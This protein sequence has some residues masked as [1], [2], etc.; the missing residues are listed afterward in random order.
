MESLISII[1]PIF[2]EEK[3]IEKTLHK[4]L[5]LPLKGEILLIND[6]SEDKTLQ[7]L[8]KIKKNNKNKNFNLKIFNC[9]HQGLGA[10]LIFGFKN[11][12]NDIVLTT[13]ADGEHN[14]SSLPNMINF[15]IKNQEKYV[16]VFATRIMKYSLIRKFYNNLFHFF[17]KNFQ[18]KDP[19]I[20]M[21][22]GTR[23][24]KLETIKKMDLQEKG[25]LIQLEMN[26]KL[27]KYG[28]VYNYFVKYNKRGIDEGKKLYG[29]E[30]NKFLIKS[31]FFSIR[32][33]LTQFSV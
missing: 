26:F 11:C 3:I 15:F 19:I 13:D 4:I 2:N 10:S 17:T 6:G 30:L 1:I 14:I 23:I 8:E 18:G 31:S 33:V 7:I 28:K 5:N 20:D 16:S 22:S 9:I 21:V 25:W 29:F 32:K 27:I 24:I 12:K